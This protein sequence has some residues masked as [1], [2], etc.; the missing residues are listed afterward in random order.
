M[1]SDDDYSSAFT[2][3]TQF[4]TKK[5]KS[6]A[7]PDNDIKAQSAKRLKSNMNSEPL[8]SAPSAFLDGSLA[9]QCD[10]TSITDAVASSQAE[11]NFAAQASGS[12]RPA[13][14]STMS[15]TYKV[16]VSRFRQ[17]LSSRE[18]TQRP[19]DWT[20]G[21]SG[22]DVAFETWPVERLAAVLERYYE[23]ARTKNGRRYAPSTL[24]AIRSALVFH[25]NINHRPRSFNPAFDPAFDAAN[26]AF[27]RAVQ[28][29]TA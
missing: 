20:R 6:T 25:L 4:P 5:R 12:G 19:P 18:Q 1:S 9:P 24:L 11:Q 28:S 7:L 29:Y 2:N 10:H 21:A 3:P 27:N 16:H 13:V 15:S 8:I 26:R 23:E 14:Q 17:W 22:R